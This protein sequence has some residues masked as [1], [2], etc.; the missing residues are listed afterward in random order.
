MS[1]HFLESAYEKDKTTSRW[2]DESY[3]VNIVG[4]CFFWVF[5]AYY[6]GELVAAILQ[7]LGVG[8]LTRQMISDAVPFA[9][10]LGWLA[11]A[12]PKMH[13]RSLLTLVNAESKLNLKRI[14]QGFGV[15]FV[16]MLVWLGVGL[17]TEPESYSLTFNP[18]T[19]S[20]LLGLAIVL[21]PIQTSAEEL[22]FRGYVL[23]GLRLMT[24]NRLVLMMVI[25]LLFSIPHWGNPEMERG[26]FIYGALNYFVWGVFATAIALKDNG[27]ELSL[28]VHAAN[29]LF[30]Y[31]F[32]T[33]PDSVV[34][35]PSMFAVYTDG[36]DA[37]L[38][39]FG[40][41]LDAVIFYAIFFGGISRPELNPTP[42]TG[43]ICDRDEVGRS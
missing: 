4:I 3:I 33:S 43:A 20:A 15:W 13:H 31:L 18:A 6:S 41:L 27:L 9:I 39:L 14:G 40:T 23:Q 10:V 5:C 35:V 38:S 25:G 16:M 37:R 21:V 28:G 34:I 22:F 32:L 29:N 30:L 17:W 26:A 42:T 12:L 2:I 11:I 1:K 36:I 19:W 8:T 7:T 24:R